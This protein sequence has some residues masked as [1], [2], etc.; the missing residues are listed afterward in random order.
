MVYFKLSGMTNCPADD[1][2]GYTEPLPSER[3][4]SSL[5]QHLE[6]W[7]VQRIEL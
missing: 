1:D 4:I 2:E 3:H 6:G 7:A 5:G